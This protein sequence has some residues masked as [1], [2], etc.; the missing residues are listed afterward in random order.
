MNK[1][2]P[3]L[4]GIRGIAI[5]MVL[6]WHYFN[7]QIHHVEPDT[8]LSYAR[9]LTSMTWSGV[10]LFFVLSGFLI[11]GIVIDNHRSPN[12]YRV[13]YLRRCCRILP[14][15]A[16]LMIAYFVLRGVLDGP[17]FAWLFADTM[18]DA[19]YLTFTQNLWMGVR[20]TLGGS[21]LGV[22]WSL[23]IEEQF[24]LFLPLLLLL[25]S[26]RVWVGLLLPLALLAPILRAA[27][28]HGLV[29]FVN[30]PFRMDALLMGAA[31]AAAL[32]HE[33]LV[34]ALQRNLWALAA[35][36]AVLAVGF[37]VLCV[38]PEMGRF[39]H[40]YLACFYTALLVAAVLAS[41]RPSTSILRLGVLRFFGL[42]S[43]G[44][45]MY[46][47]A[48]SGL[49]HGAFGNAMPTLA[50]ARDH[51]ITLG[52]LFS[53]V[54]LATA[55]YFLVEKLF[56]RLGASRSYIRPANGSAPSTAASAL[57]VSRETA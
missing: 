30:M 15:Y 11:G 8:L 35:T 14:V 32:R 55:S 27:F 37:L 19:S 26:Y 10:D 20:G 28:P 45:Y 6:V 13:F 47:Q 51:W 16:M 48:V 9:V 41:G 5:L 34:Q 24:Y 29:G 31:A 1:R 17:R 49:W 52:A 38:H 50:T 44:L 18:P 40:T 39:D 22:T 54:L 2:I 23:A 56:L 46:H 57:P 25:T 12:F 33:P 21:F 36:V 3:E 4:D 53:A 43:Y 42:I 7:G